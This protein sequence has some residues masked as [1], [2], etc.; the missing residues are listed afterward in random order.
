[1][2]SELKPCPFCGGKAKL[3]GGPDAQESY[4]IWCEGSHRINGNFNKDETIA[5]WNTRAVP[6][7]PELVRYDLACD[8]DGKYAAHIVEVELGE[9]VLYSQ[10]AAIIAAKEAELSFAVSDED[11]GAWRFWS[12]KSRDLADKNKSLRERAEAAEAKLAQHKE[13]T[14]P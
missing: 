3:Y 14:K 11:K 9:Y 2:T 10:A 5:K 13:E 12:K 1:M 8:F 4:S 6:D 7:V